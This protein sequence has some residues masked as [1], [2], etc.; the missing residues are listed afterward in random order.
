MSERKRRGMTENIY[1]VK[2]ETKSTYML[3]HILG[4]S[5]IVYKVKFPVGRNPECSCPD[6]KVRKRTCKHIYFVC[7]KVIRLVE[8]DEWCQ[9]TDLVTVADDILGR[10]SHLSSEHVL[11]DKKLQQKYENKLAGIKDDDD[12]DLHS[13]KVDIRNTECCVCLSDFS[14]QDKKSIM[15]CWTCHNGIHGVCWNKWKQINHADKCVYCRSKI[16]SSDTGTRAK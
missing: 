5:K 4:S 13:T 12:V 14:E 2:F 11:V 15:V 6:H 8:P 9:V 16:E 10:F 3:F 1:L 7:G